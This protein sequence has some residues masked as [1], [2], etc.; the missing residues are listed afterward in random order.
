MLGVFATQCGNW[1]ANSSI[2]YGPT[3]KSIFYNVISKNT[4][5]N[6]FKRHILKP[7][8]SFK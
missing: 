1:K 6:A 4:F 3:H 8:Y 2:I 5:E 7:L